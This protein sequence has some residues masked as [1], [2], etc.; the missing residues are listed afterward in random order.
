M[1]LNKHKTSS[2]R[3]NRARYFQAPPNHSPHSN[4]GASPNSPFHQA[5]SPV[6][7]ASPAQNA[8]FL[9]PGS[10]S[11]NSQ[12]GSGQAG[13]TLMPQNQQQPRVEA[14]TYTCDQCHADLLISH[15]DA[16]RCR[17]CGYRIL[18]KKRTQNAMIILDC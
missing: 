1:K 17:E 2:R 6:Q 16:I 7:S 4:F 13:S 10:P 15:K 9:G 5:A 11:Q 3:K 18:F 12:A 8:S 14:V